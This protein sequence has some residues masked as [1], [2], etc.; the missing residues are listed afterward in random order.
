MIRKHGLV[1]TAAAMLVFAAA[2]QA[3][4]PTVA[5]ADTTPPAIGEMAPDFAFRAITRNGIA[6]QNTRLS[7]YRGQTVVLWFFI[8]ARTR[9]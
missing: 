5:A 4:Q 7:D 8:K 2:T 1:T 9:G 3:Q 6:P